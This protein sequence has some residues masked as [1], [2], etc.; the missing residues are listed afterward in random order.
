MTRYLFVA[1]MLMVLVAC[2]TQ[3]ELYFRTNPQQLQ[4]AI[5]NCPEKQPSLV[6][7]EQLAEIAEDVSKL[8]YQLQVNP[9]GFGKKILALQE[10]L[11]KQKADLLTNPN[12]PELKIKIKKNEQQLVEYLAIVKWLESPES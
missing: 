8:A 9:Q 12:Q 7:C 10:N 5:D 11:A 6:S 1:A 2:S 4:K 3:D